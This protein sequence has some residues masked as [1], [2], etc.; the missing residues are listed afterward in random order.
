VTLT[1]EQADQIS[2]LGEQ[3]SLLWDKRR[4]LWI[5][6][7]DDEDGE[8]IEETDLDVLLDRLSGS[9]LSLERFR[10]NG[11]SASCPE[12]DLP[13]T[14]RKAAG[15]IGTVCQFRNDG[16]SEPASAHN[17]VMRGYVA[18]TDEDWYRFL[19]AR[20][21]I[22]E[23]E[24]NFWRPGG[25]RE[26]RALTVGEPFFFKT[27][28]PH[29]L[30]VGGGFY[31]GFAALRVSEAW[32]FFGLAN[33][34]DSLERM[35]A[36]IAY[37]RRVPIAPGDDPE[38]GCVFVRN[39]TFFPEN[40]AFQ[41]PP[42]FASNIVQGKSYD[43]SEPQVSSYFGDLMQLVLGAQIEIDLSQPWHDAGPVFGDPRLAPYRL[44]QRSFQ[45]VVL[46]TY[47][48][49]CAITGSKIRPVLQAAHIRPVTKGGENRIDN[50][51]LLRSDV[52]TMFD[53]GY[54]AVT[55]SY[56]LRVSPRLQDDFG[57]GEQF[58]AQ[59]GQVIALPDRKIDRPHREFLEWHL[60]EVFKAC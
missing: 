22:S 15:R 31:S 33:G 12:C 46:N 14:F 32:R 37:Y 24:V 16:Q 13:P 29:N 58:Y 42:G 17:T 4:R 23:A 3:W 45:A 43:L 59:A 54:L 5:A 34:A 21:E 55:P 1:C 35:R 20:P 11:P 53:N 51:L 56:R 18:V 49:H 50:G 60:E 41:P 6:A 52:H 10:G 38:I 9:R 8:Q 36:R 40:A 25:G 7:E 57:N 48:G 30:I 28:S 27:H 26:F 39:V 47:H 2:R 44:A 19:A